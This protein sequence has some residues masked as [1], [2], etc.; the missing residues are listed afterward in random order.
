MQQRAYALLGGEVL[1]AV[2]RLLDEALRGWCADW[3]AARDELALECRRAWDCERLLPAVP[4]WRQPWTSAAGVMALAW[5]AEMAAQVQRLLFGAERHHAAHS[6]V[7]HSALAAG[8]AGWQDLLRRLQAV[9]AG[10]ATEGRSVAPPA[11]DLWRYA[12]G[13]LLVQVQLGRHSAQLLLDHGLTQALMTQLQARGWLQHPPA[14]PLAALD[15]T[16]LLAAQPV[17]LA[18]ALGQVE[19]DLGSLM[20]LQTGD[21]IRLERAADRALPVR[22]PS[23]AALFDGYLGRSGANMALELVPHDVSNGAKHE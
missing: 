6:G 4:Q 17:R 11:A 9:V 8:E 23:G 22:G 21:V 10:G 20:R 5:P 7:A 14:A 12:S 13:A 18:V 3:G 2:Q 1:A 16:A 15:L 19:V